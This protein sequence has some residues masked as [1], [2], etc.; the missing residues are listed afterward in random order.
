MVKKTA[1]SDYQRILVPVDF[2]PNSDAAAVV[3]A[4]LAREID[5][6]MFHA[7]DSIGEIALR[8]TDVRESVIREI[9]ARDES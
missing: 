9:P 8:E 5:L 3:A 1:E 7:F 4:A 2:T 6:H